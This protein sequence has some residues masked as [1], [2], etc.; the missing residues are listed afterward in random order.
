MLFIHLKQVLEDP[1]PSLGCYSKWSRNG[2]RERSRGWDGTLKTATALSLFQG[3]TAGC[4]AE[5]PCDCRSADLT[6]LL[7]W[8]LSSTILNIRRVGMRNPEGGDVPSSKRMGGTSL[9]VQWLR[10]LSPNTG[11]LCSIPGQGP[12]SYMP[13]QRSKIPYAT[14][15]TQCSQI[16]K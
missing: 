5:H 12:R 6:H 15:K 13:Q 10:L 8:V 2:G 9:V 14:T 3:V 11:G 16:N 1:L 7:S 4:L